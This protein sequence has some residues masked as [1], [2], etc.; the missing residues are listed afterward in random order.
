MGEY[1]LKDHRAAHILVNFLR[2]QAQGW[3]TREK[4][5]SLAG[6]PLASP[7]QLQAAARW[8]EKADAWRAAAGPGAAPLLSAAGAFSPAAPLADFKALLGQL[9]GQYDAMSKRLNAVLD[10][11]GPLHERRRDVQYVAA[12]L[13]WIYYAVNNAVAGDLAFCEKWGDAEL[14][15]A[16]EGHLEASDKEIGFVNYIV[17]SFADEALYEPQVCSG[18]APMTG[19]ALNSSL[20]PWA[21]QADKYLTLLGC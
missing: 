19:E 15:A 8:V 10:E 13:G 7:E 2:S 11:P 3:Y 17:G 21:G 14:R 1:T 9:F 16:R 5:L 6:H 20:R 18:L 12:C 4:V